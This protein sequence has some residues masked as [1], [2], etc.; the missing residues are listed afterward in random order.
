[1]P[2]PAELA[3]ELRDRQDRVR[4]FFVERLA[5]LDIQET[6]RTRS[7]NVVDWL[8][9]REL[10][11]PPPP[12]RPPRQLE[13]GEAYAKTELQAQP[14]ARGPAGTVPKIRFD[15]ESYLKWIGDD[16][17]MQPPLDGVH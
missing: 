7:G 9:K 11:S 15:V 14:E 17:P 13:E 3:A 10:S 16:V 4:A 2:S 1:M 5:R 12:P 8:P 6:T